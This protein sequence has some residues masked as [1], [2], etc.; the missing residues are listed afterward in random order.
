MSHAQESGLGRK[1]AI[2]AKLK[3][4][5]QEQIAKECQMSRISVNRF[6]RQHTEIRAGDLASLLGILGVDLAALI[7]RAIEKQ[8]NGSQTVDDPLYFDVATILQGL[9]ELTRKTLLDQIKFWSLQ[10]KSGAERKASDRLVA[11]VK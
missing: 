10:L 9:D 6:F 7:D 1:L 5:T 3:G 2:L 11:A 8:M 4:M